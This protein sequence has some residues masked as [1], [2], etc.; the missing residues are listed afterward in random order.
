MSEKNKEFVVQ[1]R[2]RFAP[3]GE[4]R[5]DADVT[6]EEKPATPSV[7]A[8]PPIQAAPPPPQQQAP[9]PQA[10]EADE[11]E[12]PAPPTAAEQQE[13]KDAYQAS[14]K[15]IDEMISKA[16]N[17]ENAPTQMTFE[18]LVES[19]YM[20]ALLQLGAIRQENEQPRVDILGARQTIDSLS[21]LQEKTKGNLT[22]REQTLL[23][24]VLFELRMAWIEITNAIAHAPRPESGI[25]TPG[26][27]IK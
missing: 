4:L 2:R 9:V 12:L 16:G 19:F 6:E 18:R 8:T 11:E 14:G 24:N 27:K 26:G 10:S 23:Q 5:K 25:V 7:Q 20:T 13:Q 22:E 15:Q 17:R 21:I 1:D 3:E